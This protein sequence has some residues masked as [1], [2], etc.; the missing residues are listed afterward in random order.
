MLRKQAS[1]VTMDSAILTVL[2]LHVRILMSLKN[3]SWATGT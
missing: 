1:V 2:I 3:M